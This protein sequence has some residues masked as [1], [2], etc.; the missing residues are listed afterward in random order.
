MSAPP[1]GYEGARPR[2]P[3]TGERSPLVAKPVNI[4]EVKNQRI[5]LGAGALGLLA[6]AVGPWVTALG[7]VSIG[8]T[9]NVEISIVVFGGVLMLALCA[10]L[11]KKL[12]HASMVVGGLALLE[13][14]Y[15]LFQLADARSEAGEWGAL[16]SPGWGL[17]LTMIVS[18]FM[19]VST[20]VVKR[21][22][23]ALVASETRA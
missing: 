5:A 21:R 12:R 16:I 3:V 20:F 8:P 9:A 7:V 10:F 6:G 4:A 11:G 13:T 19:I 22:P 18:A 1:P 15:V 14:V 17:F 2:D 23:E